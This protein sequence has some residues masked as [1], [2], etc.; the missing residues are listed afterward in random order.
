MYLVV[1]AFYS[2]NQTVIDTVSARTAA[3]AQ[4][5]ALITAIN[6]RIAGQSATSK[7]VTQD[8][9]AVRTTLDNITHATM[10]LARAWALATGNNTLAEE[11]NYPL[12]DIERIKDDTMQGFCNYRIQIVN[13][14]LAAMADYGI[15]ATTVTEWQDALN[16]YVAILEAPREAINAKHLNTMGLKELFTETTKLFKEQLNP[17]MVPFKTS[18]PELYAGYLQACKV[19]DRKGPGGSTV[20]PDMIEIGIYMYD[21]VTLMPIAGGIFRVLN[22][23]V[24]GPV[25]V[26]T[27]EQGLASVKLSGYAPNMT[28][29]VDME[30]WADG[31]EMQSGQLDMLPGNRYSFDSPMQPIVP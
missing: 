27:N 13:D 3:F 26:V 6:S 18:D 12:S 2:S 15:A 17:L 29:W 30:A 31:Y 24:G 4:L 8:K 28:V 19:I 7:G 23:P 9:Q 16:A 1:S 25:E 22:P 10:S 20:P 14:N 5:D 11:F 21:S